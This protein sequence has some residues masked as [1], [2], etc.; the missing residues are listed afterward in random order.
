MDTR[1]TRV[2]TE[3]ANQYSGHVLNG[4]LRVFC[5]SNKEY[6]DYRDGESSTSQAS[7]ELSGIIGLRQ[8]CLLI[9]AEAQFRAVTAF[10]THRVPT[11]LGSTRQWLL[12]GSDALTVERADALR[13]M[14]SDCEGRFHR[15][16]SH[17]KRLH[18]SG[19]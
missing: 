7:L 14:L 10:L 6:A 16:G 9:P 19:I 2:T 4:D 1:R 17:F 11:L 12:Q 13:Q 3:L 18:I 5:V 8:F 15:V